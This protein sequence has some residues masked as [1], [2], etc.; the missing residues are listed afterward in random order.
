MLARPFATKQMTTTQLGGSQ[1]A[2]SL[3]LRLDSVFRLANSQR[4]MRLSILTAEGLH[5]SGKY[6]I[7]SD[8][9]YEFTIEFLVRKRDDLLAQVQL[10]NELIDGRGKATNIIAR[11]DETASDVRPVKQRKYE[12]WDP[13]RALEVHLK[14]RRRGLKIPLSEAISILLKNGVDPGKPRGRIT[15]P[16]ALVSRTLKIAFPNKPD[17]FD[18]TPKGISKKT[19]KTIVK[20]GTPDDQVLVGLAAEADIPKRRVRE[21]SGQAVRPSPEG[22]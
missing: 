6:G 21:R 2:V 19:G 11:V 8:V 7:L 3:V 18:W 9:S 22:D 20:K 12:G 5:T 14:A 10:L 1:L 17:T 13:T 16:Y 4:S 15:D